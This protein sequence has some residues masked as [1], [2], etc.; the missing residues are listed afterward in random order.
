MSGFWREFKFIDIGSLSF[1]SAAIPIAFMTLLVAS[2]IKGE[3]KR[4]A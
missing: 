4:V 2:G 1:V 3:R